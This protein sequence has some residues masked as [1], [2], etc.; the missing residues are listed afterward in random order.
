MSAT[1]SFTATVSLPPQFSSYALSANQF[2]FSWFGQNGVGYQVEFK[3]NLSAPTWSP[4]G[5]S[6]YGT[7]AVINVTNNISASAQRFFRLR[8]LPP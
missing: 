7:G 2:R 5:G 4:L 8:I 3:D 6:V 1:Q